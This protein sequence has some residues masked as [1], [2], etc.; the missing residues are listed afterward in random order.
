MKNKNNLIHMGNSHLSQNN[1]ISNRIFSFFSEFVCLGICISSIVLKFQELKK[2]KDCIKKSCYIN[3]DDLGLLKLL[4][5]I[6][7]SFLFE[8]LL[9][10]IITISWLILRFSKVNLSLLRFIAINNNIVGIFCLIFQVWFN[11][12][13]NDCKNSI[14]IKYKTTNIIL[15]VLEIAILVVTCL[16]CC[17]NDFIHCK[18]C[19]RK[20][21]EKKEIQQNDLE[22]KRL[23]TSS[24]KKNLN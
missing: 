18:L 20:K 9:V 11:L 19:Q 8:L 23:E 24:S 3:N 21:K 10:E 17:L 6:Q 16:S 7:I 22:I 12:F 2:V 1:K 4:K 13:P 5:I 15:I 14:N